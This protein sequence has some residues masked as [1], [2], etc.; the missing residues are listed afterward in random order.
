MGFEWMAGWS[1]LR[2][3]WVRAPRRVS[4]VL[5]Q[6]ETHWELSPRDLGGLGAQDRMIISKAPFA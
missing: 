3:H 5:N 1:M 6:G 4:C 2:A